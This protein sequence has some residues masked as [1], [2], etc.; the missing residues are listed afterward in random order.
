MQPRGVLACHMRRKEMALCG[1]GGLD[2]SWP[3]GLAREW[4]RLG[5]TKNKLMVEK[6]NGEEGSPLELWSVGTGRREA[7]MVRSRRVMR[8]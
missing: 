8:G 4:P 3:R 6:L 1:G 5:Q 2:V 7:I